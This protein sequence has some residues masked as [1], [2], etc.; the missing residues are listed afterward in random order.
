MRAPFAEWFLFAVLVAIPIGAV[1]F[2]VCRL[3]RALWF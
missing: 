3:A 1:V 2:V